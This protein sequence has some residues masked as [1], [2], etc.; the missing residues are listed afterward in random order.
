MHHELIFALFS[1]SIGSLFN[2][3]SS[4]NVSYE[5]KQAEYTIHYR[6]AKPIKAGEEL[7]IFYGHSVR[8]AGDPLPN[9]E[10]VQ[11]VD[12]DGWGGLGGLEEESE[13]NE[14]TVSPRTAGFKK[15]TQAQLKERDLEVIGFD[16]PTFPF[17]KI[18]EI[19]DPE[20]AELTTSEFDEF[21]PRAFIS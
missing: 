8:F 10:S 7:F 9:D 6:A 14:G 5:I 1:V 17:K 11:E 19:I 13:G 4:P 21:C 16:E 18:T 3:S 15:L 20:D 2:H 12:D